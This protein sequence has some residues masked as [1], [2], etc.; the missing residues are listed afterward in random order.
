MLTDPTPSAPARLP[1]RSHRQALDWSLVLASQGIEHSLDHSEA[2]G[3]GLLV[4]PELHPAALAVI[5]QYR[6]ENRRWPWRRPL[7]RTHEIF[8]W[9]VLAWVLLTIV[10]FGLSRERPGLEAAGI[11]QGTALAHGEWWRAF[12]ATLLHA[13][14]P[15]LASNALFG[16]ILIGLAM[17]RHGTGV[18][19]LAALLAGG[20]GNLISAW[21]HGKTF[22]G[23]GAS[24]VVMGALGLVAIQSAA[25]LRNHSR[26]LKLLCAGVAAGVMLFV[27]L[28]LTPGTDVAAHAGGFVAGLGLGLL[29][30]RIESWTQRPGV[31]IAAALVLAALVLGSW[32]LALR[33]AGGTL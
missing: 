21:V 6:L 25:W 26:A 17:G 15:H 4:A 3:W 9:G 29:L 14:L 23:L 10:F 16:F 8:D 27:L 30:A 20:C 33:H 5:R 22:Q 11:M 19:L 28:G 1:A 2:H 12:T 18:G 31:N 13:D 24:G 7:P 32:A